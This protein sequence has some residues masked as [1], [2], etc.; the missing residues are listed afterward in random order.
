MSGTYGS[1]GGPA[2]QPAGPTRRAGRGGAGGPADGCRS[3]EPDGHGDPQGITG[4][5]AAAGFSGRVRL[6]AAL[7]GGDARP[8]AVR[9]GRP[10][11][12]DAAAPVPAA[13]VS[14]G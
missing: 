13:V 3:G 2:G 11:V 9:R 7:P 14:R 12:V 6:A 5:A 8:G 1:E 10:G 4:D